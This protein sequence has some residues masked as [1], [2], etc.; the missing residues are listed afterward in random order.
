MSL[1]VL[2]H[3]GGLKPVDC[4]DISSDDAL[5][6][7]GSSVVGCCFGLITFGYELEEWI[8]S[9]DFILIP[10]FLIVPH[11]TDRCTSPSM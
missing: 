7:D 6:M 5:V 4:Q 10:S 9:V 8:L 11:A 2:A 3:E 1:G